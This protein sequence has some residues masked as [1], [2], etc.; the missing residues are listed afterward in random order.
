MTDVK[1]NVKNTIANIVNGVIKP[2]PVYKKEQCRFCKC[3]GLCNYNEVYGNIERGNKTYPSLESL[4]GG[5]D[6]E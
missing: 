4:L 6:N 1:E 3:L 2:E 5:D